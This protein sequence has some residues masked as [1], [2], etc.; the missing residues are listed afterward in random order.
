MKTFFNFFVLSIFISSLSVAQDTTIV[1]TLTYDSTGRN[2]MFEF[3]K[4]TGQNYEKILMQ[5]SMRCK[6][7]KVSTGTDRNLGCGEWDY[8]C[9]TFITDSSYTDSV[10]SFHPSHIIPG[11]NGDKFLYTTDTVYTFYKFKQF[12]VSTNSIIAETSHVIGNGNKKIN[13]PF[14][15]SNK[16]SKSQYLFKSSELIDVGLQAGEISG[17]N[18]DLLSSHGKVDLLRIKMKTVTVDELNTTTPEMEGF[19]EVYFKNTDLIPGIN[20]LNFYKHFEWDGISNILVEFSYTNSKKDS[21]LLI[22]GDIL[23]KNVG[24]ITSS[25]DNFLNFSGIGKVFLN[26]TDFSLIDDEITIGFWAFG[27][28][29]KLPS[30]TSAFEGVDET[31]L[32][33]I[34]V[35]LPWS[36]SGIYWDCG[37][38]GKGYDRI[39]KVA[40][41]AEI[42]GKWNHWTF[43][44]NASTGKMYIYLNGDLWH[45]G[46]GK[47]KSIDI[48]KFVFGSS[49]NNN[50][51][52]QGFIDD[53]TVWNTSLSTEIIKEYLYKNIDENHPN[54]SNLLAYYKLDKNNGLVISDSSPQNNSAIY[55]GVIS[56]KFLR[57]DQLFKGFE[58]SEFRPKLTFYQGEYQQV[59][60]EVEVLDSIMNDIN[61]VYYYGT[62]N[63]KIV[64]I[65]SAFVS[66]AGYSYIINGRTNII[67]DSIYYEPEDSIIISDLLYYNF[68]PSR[69][70]IMSFVT[71]YGIGLDLGKDGKTWEFDVSDFKP[72]LNGKKRLTVEFGKYQ[73]ELDIK[74]L[75]ISGTPPRNVNN[76]QQI[77]RAGSSRSYQNLLNDR[78]FEPR[79]V[80]LDNSSAMFKIRT[81]ITG[82]GQEGE[83]IPRSHYININGGDKELVW[84]VWKECADNPIYPQG[85]TWVYDRAGWCPGAPTDVEELD[86][87][88]LAFPDQEIEIDYGIATASGDSRY[89]I[90]SQLVSYGS[91]NFS[92]DAGIIEIQRPSKRTEFQRF[93]P[94]CYN[95]LI[96]IQNRGSE[97]LTNLEIEYYVKGGV[98]KIFNWTGSLGFLEKEEITL[99]IDNTSFW[100]GDGTNVFVAS[101]KNVDEYSQNDKIESEFD[102]PDVLQAE[103]IMVLRTNN[104][105]NENSLTIKNMDGDIV[106]SKNNLLNN[107]TY[108]ENLNLAQGC[109]EVELTDSGN[110]GL[111]FWANS[112]QGAGD[113]Y[114]M[115]SN[116]LRIKNFNSDFGKFLRYSFLVGNIDRVD[117]QIIEN[118]FDVF[119]NPSSGLVKLKMN[120][121]ISDDSKILITDISGNLIKTISNK[122]LQNK[123][124]TIDLTDLTN[125]LYLF[126][127]KDEN[128][129]IVNKV[130]IQ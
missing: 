32:R 22:A 67:A 70:E 37:N 116:F 108:K 59:V 77:W 53:F 10:K 57:G 94:I 79:L 48:K 87:E 114:F 54:Y 88:G 12:D 35:H 83:F 91:P 68:V 75:F 44:K 52:Y 72:I 56:R 113:L 109:Y 117:N 85:G 66:K 43:T 74:F 115:K 39:D 130:V 118:V 60:D 84:T 14:N 92:F 58:T 16:R 38:D 119:P 104:F 21:D 19:T 89:I 69:F 34:N 126:N 101:I 3:P 49:F 128:I 86:L 90:N 47:V 2:Y 18:I 111:A 30:N 51:S 50:Y 81:A 124:Y 15:L 5:Y 71:P 4:D 20:R 98:K 65:D 96:V 99:P 23:D 27:N 105:G 7:A 62:E 13:H 78:F 26:N 28:P 36:N 63:N 33:Q 11:Y 97:T 45:T 107:T 41:S 95:P 61:V 17:L 6:G 46:S 129:S 112:A 121:D 123:E 110:D 82:H 125:G 42:E 122:Q 120:I 29:D 31:N 106:V 100:I 8:S 80:K 102:L 76:I 24:L 55:S 127:Y 103:F 73:E 9:N 25:D 93:N 64:L 1:Q 40:T